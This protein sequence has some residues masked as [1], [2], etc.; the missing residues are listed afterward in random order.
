MPKIAFAPFRKAEIV[1]LA[2]EARKKYHGLS[3]D[4][5]AELENIILIREPDA[6]SK[7][8]G[9]ASSIRSEAPKRIASLSRPG[10]YLLSFSEKEITLH[11]AI[12]I[13]PLYG[14]PEQEIFWH[15]FYH[16]W[17]SPTRKMKADFFHQY[18]TDTVLEN[19]E[20]KRANIFAAYLLI[21]NVEQEDTVQS[22]SEKWNV[23]CE[24][25]ELRLFVK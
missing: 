10:S 9:Y 23:S 25:A 22:V 4:E 12:V 7:K 16:L 2:E 15:E 19:Q 13:N 11:D 24:M 20:E 18:S 6:R 3:I 14:I 5:V 21:P 1:A 17:Y 8:A